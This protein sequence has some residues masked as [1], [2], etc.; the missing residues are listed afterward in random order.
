[1]NVLLRTTNV[2]R[3]LGFSMGPLRSAALPQSGCTAVVPAQGMAYKLKTNKS[4]A[5][6]FKIH[7]KTGTPYFVASGSG[8]KHPRTMVTTKRLKRMIKRL[9][10]YS[11]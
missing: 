2:L 7:K 3:G 6:R 5:K 1:M 8:K 11:N 9:I 4:A 10:P